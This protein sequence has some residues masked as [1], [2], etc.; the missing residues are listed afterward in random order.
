MSGAMKGQTTE[1][2]LSRGAAIGAVAGAVVSMEVLESCLQGELLSKVGAF[3]IISSHYYFVTN[4]PRK[5]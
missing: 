1:T 5:H 3:I 2:G 4:F